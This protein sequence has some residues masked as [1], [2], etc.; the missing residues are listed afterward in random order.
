V[1][2]I[3]EPGP[4]AQIEPGWYYVLVGA[5]GEDM[6]WSETYTRPEDA[7]RGARDARKAMRR[8]KIV[9]PS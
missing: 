3:R 1:L 8:A 9:L 2:E 7:E 4:N 6:C 5:N